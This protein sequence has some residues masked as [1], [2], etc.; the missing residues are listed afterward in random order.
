MFYPVLELAKY[1]VVK[2]IHDDYPISNLQLQKILFYIQREFLHRMNKPAFSESIEAW[3]FGPVVPEVYYYFCGA[4]AMRIGVCSVPND[5]FLSMSKDD[6]LIIDSIIERKR[7]LNP[8]DMVAETHK[9]GGAWDST[10][11]GG[12]GNRA[13][14]PV[15][16]IRR[17]G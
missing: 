4:G 17:L 8:W 15:S 12:Y 6:R 16:E 1:I 13:I 2:C 3:P 14:I 7:I 5:D 10:Y 11:R 9:Q